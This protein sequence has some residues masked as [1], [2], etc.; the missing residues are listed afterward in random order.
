MQA[1]GVTDNASRLSVRESAPRR[2]CQPEK[3]APAPVKMYDGDFK[4]FSFS[5]QLCIL[6]RRNRNDPTSSGL[7]RLFPQQIQGKARASFRA[8][9]IQSMKNTAW[10][11]V[12]SLSL[13]L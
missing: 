12:F 7:R 4:C 10:A 2:P 9:R 5:E 11:Q 3:C 8:Q 13:S 6:F 1:D